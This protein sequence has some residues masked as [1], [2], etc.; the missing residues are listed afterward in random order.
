MQ[1][2][3]EKIVTV[4]RIVEVEK[5]VT[6]IVEVNKEAHYVIVEPGVIRDDLNHHLKQFGLF[7]G[8]M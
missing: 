3:V 8:T 7:Y 5:I 1:V 2:I 4:D 6:K